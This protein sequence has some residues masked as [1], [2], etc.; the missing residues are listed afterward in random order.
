MNYV[1]DP[2]VDR[3]I[4][5]LPE[6]QAALCRELRDLIHAADD[7]MVETIKRTDRPYFTLEGNVGAL[8]AAKDH[9]NLFIYD[10]G[11]VPDPEGMITSGNDNATARTIA[12]WQGDSVN[13]AALLVMLRQIVADNRAGGW[14]KIKSGRA[15][16]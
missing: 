1:T 7:E 8:A 14:R 5:A 6:W 10:G 12:F 16:T 3:Y 4:D 15:S 2:R 11:I 13:T 9:V